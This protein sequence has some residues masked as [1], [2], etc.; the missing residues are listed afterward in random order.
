M[1]T[2]L[3]RVRLGVVLAAMSLVAGVLGSAIWAQTTPNTYT[4]CLA[5]GVITSVKIGT[6]P[7]APCSKQATQISW[8]EQGTP[9]T[10][11]ADGEDGQPGLSKAFWSGVTND[12]LVGSDFSV[13]L[14]ET[15]PIPRVFYSIIGEIKVS[16]NKTNIFPAG[17]ECFL[18]VSGESQGEGGEYTSGNDIT[19]LLNLDFTPGAEITV[20]IRLLADPILPASGATWIVNIH[21]DRRRQG[22]DFALQADILVIPTEDGQAG[23][24]VPLPQ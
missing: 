13:S 20:P 4:G 19:S 8:N 10:P 11:G 14:A 24:S 7:S 21:C 5:G 12:A 18:R 17:V 2:T 16:A 1:R 3:V 9:G 6:S 15:G 22:G 23:V